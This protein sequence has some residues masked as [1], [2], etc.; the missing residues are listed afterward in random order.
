MRRIQQI[1][2]FF[3]VRQI[4]LSLYYLLILAA[5]VAMYGR[6]DFSAPDFIYQGF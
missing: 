5:L 3:W 2:H 6:G 1:W 4:F